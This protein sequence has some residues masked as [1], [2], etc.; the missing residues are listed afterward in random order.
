MHERE[1]V[2]GVQRKA[3]DRAACGNLVMVVG[4]GVCNAAATG[5][6]AVEASFVEGF[7][8][9][10]ERARSRYLLRIDQLLAASELA[11]GDIVLNIGDHHRDDREGLRHAS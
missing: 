3:S 7:E 11:G 10:Y 8:K 9:G 2:D 5:S 1:G 6:D 4:I